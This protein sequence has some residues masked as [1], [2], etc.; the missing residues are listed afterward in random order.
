MFIKININTSKKTPD[1]RKCGYKYILYMIDD[2]SKYTKA[3]LIQDKEANMVV[4]AVYTH[5]IIG[6]NGLGHGTP[7]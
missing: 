3:V 2:F 7:G 6:T 1:H 5:W 4:S